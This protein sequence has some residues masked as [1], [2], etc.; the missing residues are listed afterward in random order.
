MNVANRELKE[1]LWILERSGQVARLNGAEDGERPALDVALFR[2]PV[3]ARAT[4]YLEQLACFDERFEVLSRALDRRKSKG[5]LDLAYRRRLT[6]KDS[7]LDV[8]E[9]AF[10]KVGG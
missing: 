3:T 2:E 10:A 4:G 5:L 6:F 9:D 7:T 8:A 1:T